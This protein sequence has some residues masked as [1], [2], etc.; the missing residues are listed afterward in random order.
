MGMMAVCQS[1]FKK[2]QQY[3]S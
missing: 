1:I 3:P 2:C